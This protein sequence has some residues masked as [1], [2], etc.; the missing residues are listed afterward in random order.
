MPSMWSKHGH[1]MFLPLEEEHVFWTSIIAHYSNPFW[2]IFPYATKGIFC[3]NSTKCSPFNFE[4][5]FWHFGFKFLIFIK[6]MLY[7]II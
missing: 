6:L 3:M 2:G 5:K 1:M 4:L 7:T